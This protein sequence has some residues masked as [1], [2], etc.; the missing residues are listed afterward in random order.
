MHIYVWRHPKDVAWMPE[1]LR[2]AETNDVCPS[3]AS[4]NANINFTSQTLRSISEEKYLACLIKCTQWKSTNRSRAMFLLHFYGKLK[5]P[6]SPSEEQQMT[7]AK[8]KKP[9]VINILAKARDL[10]SR[11]SHSGEISRHAPFASR[12][13]RFNAESSM[14]NSERSCCLAKLSTEPLA[15]IMF[16]RTNAQIQFTWCS[17]LMLSYVIVAASP[18]SKSTEY[19]FSRGKALKFDDR[20]S[21]CHTRSTR[22]HRSSSRSESRDAEARRWNLS[23]Q[24]IVSKMFQSIS[25]RKRVRMRRLNRPR[26]YGGNQRERQTD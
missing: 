19:Q 1:R 15:E 22:L 2:F 3:S 26:E 20:G 18:H 11:R 24:S 23:K 10:S 25:I 4:S 9:E 6:V 8:Q 14:P 21:I 17:A 16:N 13:Q 7:G 5:I 12:N